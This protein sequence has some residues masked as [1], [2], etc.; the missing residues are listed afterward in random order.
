LP[1]FLDLLGSHLFGDELAGFVSSLR[2]YEMPQLG[3]HQIVG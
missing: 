2:G 1:G 3:A